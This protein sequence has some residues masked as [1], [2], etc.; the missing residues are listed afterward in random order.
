M[1]APSATREAVQ[2]RMPSTW[3][4]MISWVLLL[5]VACLAWRMPPWVLMVALAGGMFA[6]LKVI[7]WR[8]AA[9]VLKPPRARSLAYLLAWPGLDALAFLDVSRRTPRPASAEWPRAAAKAAAGAIVTWGLVRALAAWQPYLAALAG[10]AGILLLLHFG[11]FHL[12]ALAWQA[13]GVDAEPVMRA[14]LGASSLADFWG[15]RWNTAFSCLTRQWVL[16]PLR[17]RV[18]LA[19]ALVACFLLS[20]LVH[21]IA[22]SL[23]AR[24]GWG[25]PT[26]YFLIQGVGIAVERS[27]PCWRL[28]LGAGWLGRAYALSVAALPVPLLVHAPFAHRVVIP[29]LDAIGALP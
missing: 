23:P 11:V 22:I 5:L 24:G 3:L 19:A 26:L 13:R 10:A 15:D 9:R 27:Q 7:T 20:G 16:Q 21:E 17:R 29:L 28:G 14:P 12:V 8:L 6:T 25:L 18:P 1:S 2:A 4:D